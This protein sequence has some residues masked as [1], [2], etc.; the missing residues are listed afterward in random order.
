MRFRFVYY[1]SYPALRATLPQTIILVK[2][3]QSLTLK[4]A[5]GMQAKFTPIFYYLVGF[6]LQRMNN[7]IAENGEL[8]PVIFL[9]HEV[10][11]WRNAI[12]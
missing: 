5:A 11:K 7:L 10:E 8:I 6:G 9:L 2:L 12:D 1:P 3:D 4:C